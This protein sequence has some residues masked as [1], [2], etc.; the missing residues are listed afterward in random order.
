MP[1]STDSKMIIECFSVIR[2]RK[3]VDGGTAITVTVLTKEGNY[4]QLQLA[5]PKDV[6]RLIDLLKPYAEEKS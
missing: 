5:T 4:E 1:R 3:P 2:A 6:S